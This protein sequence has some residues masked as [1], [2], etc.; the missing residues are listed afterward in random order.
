MTT[1]H[2]VAIASGVAAGLTAAYMLGRSSRSEKAEARRWRRFFGDALNTNQLVDSFVA[3]IRKEAPS[4]LKP[5]ENLRKSNPESALGEAVVFGI[6]QQLGLNPAIADAPGVGGADFLCTYKPGVLSNLAVPFV[7]EAT[8]LDPDAVSRKSSW[9]NSVPDEISGGPFGLITD[10]IVE[11]AAKKIPQLA[12]HPMP[13]V[14]AIASSHAGSSV[15]LDTLAA[16]SVLRSEPKIIQPLDGSPASQAV[17]I[18]NSAFLRWDD[19]G[20]IVTQRESISAVLLVS[21]VGNRSL[22]LGVLHPAPHYPLDL[23]MLPNVP[24]VKIARWPLEGHKISVEWVLGQ[25]SPRPF[26]HKLIRTI[27]SARASPGRAAGSAK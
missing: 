1:A 15:L 3:Y 20:N 6:L 16:R 10:R 19:T 14:L 24:F 5:F 8:T 7:V 18:D 2:K 26:K 25:P 9:P 17:D 11:R 4:N 12:K 23:D 21:I 22:V 27:E 13:R